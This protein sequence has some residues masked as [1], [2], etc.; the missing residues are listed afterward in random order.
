[1]FS[2]LI[3]LAFADTEAKK[4]GKEANK[5]VIK[6]KPLFNEKKVQEKKT[7]INTCSVRKY[8][9]KHSVVLNK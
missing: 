2:P 3:G 9:L 5:T 7:V 8:Q 1:M 4:N 6:L